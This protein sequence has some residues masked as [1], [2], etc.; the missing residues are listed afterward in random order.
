MSKVSSRWVP[1]NLNVHNRRNAW[2]H[3]RPSGFEYKW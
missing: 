3:A 1:Q 2:P